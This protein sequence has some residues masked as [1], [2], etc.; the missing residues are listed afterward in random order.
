MDK[1]QDNSASGSIFRDAMAEREILLI[2]PS[3][4]EYIRVAIRAVE[5]V[6]LYLGL[7]QDTLNEL[8]ISVV[9]ACNNSIEHGY[10]CNPGGEVRL[11]IR[12]SGR[13]IEIHIRD[14]GRGFD[15]GK[16]KEYNPMDQAE[17]FNYRGRGIFMMR[18][19]MDDI[20]FWRDD[21]GAM[22][23]LMTKRIS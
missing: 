18:K 3:S 4:F 1:N 10:S 2:L 23:V 17:L 16:V 22:N 9:E 6:A 5:S 12:F 20:E 15:I 8:V 7:D 11:S 21:D 19:F 14:R 13:S